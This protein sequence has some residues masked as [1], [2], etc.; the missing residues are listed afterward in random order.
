MKSNHK[1][2]TTVEETETKGK[3]KYDL[4]KTAQQGAC[5]FPKLR[6]TEQEAEWTNKLYNMYCT[7]NYA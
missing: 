5:C 7:I 2:I 1:A 4:A 6:L 3:T